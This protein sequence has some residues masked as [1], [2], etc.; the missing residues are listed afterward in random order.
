MTGAT[1][2]GKRRML[3][4][5]IEEITDFFAELFKKEEIW[6]IL[7]I[8]GI[9]G[10]V[11]RVVIVNPEGLVARLLHIVLALWWLWLFAVL[12]YLTEQ[13][14]LHWRQELFKRAIKFSVVELRMPREVTK[15]PIA[16]EQVLRS[17]HALRNSAGDIREKYWEGEV[18]VWF[19]LEMVSFGGQVHFYV[20]CQSSRKSLVEAAFFSYYPDVE[21][22]DVEDYVSKL[23]KDLAEMH[24]K[25]LDVW[26]TEMLLAKDPIYPI[27]TYPNFESMEEDKQYDPISAF[28]EI[29]GKLKPEETVCIQ[30]L[31]APAGPDW[32]KPWEKKIVEL[33]TPKTM[34]MGTGDE[35]RDV[36]MARSPGQTDVLKAV[37]QNV[38]KPAFL[39]LVRFLYLSPAATYSDTFAR[40]G[41][42][43][44]FNQYAALNLNSFKPNRMVA[45]RAQIWN[46]PHAYPKVRVDYRK[47][48]LLWNYP[49]REVPPEV[50]LG[51][52]FTSYPMNFNFASQRFFMNVEGIATLFHP[53]TAVVLTAPHIQRVESK[54]AGPPA[55]LAI[56]G[57]EKEL[58]RFSDTD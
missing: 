6:V 35:A 53:P 4:H 52:L 54:K 57:E 32:A 44:A 13:L 40:R 58:G 26:G 19:A 21:I 36:A 16:M 15:N 42:T 17:I 38:S 46:W 39:T 27:K 25:G 43:G 37:E 41:L 51:R 55:G 3:Q 33:Q 22:V 29:L 31:I 28:L 7:A 20:R 1:T 50:W 9:A 2:S 10:V 23:P 12:L 45:T 48:R 56:Y 18:T 47:Q 11:A 34:V 8:A 14:W 49:R 5:I 24:E 30:I